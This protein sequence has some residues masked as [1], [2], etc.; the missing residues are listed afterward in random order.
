M[1]KAGLSTPHGPI[2]KEIE[3][4]NK[5]IRRDHAHARYQRANLKVTDLSVTYEAG[6]AL[7]EVTFELPKAMRLAVVG[8][9][10][11]GKSTLLK[12]IAG[13]LTPSRRQS[14]SVW[15]RAGQPYLHRLC[16]A[17]QPGGLEFPRQRARCGDDGPDWQA[18]TCSAAPAAQTGQP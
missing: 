6:Y 15:R 14:R 2:I 1:L 7:K 13:V 16:A 17:A 4:T 10:G 8:P 9:N 11:A 3:K 12:V 18:G 5:A